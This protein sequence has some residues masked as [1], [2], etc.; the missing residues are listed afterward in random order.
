MWYNG[1]VERGREPACPRYQA[2]LMGNSSR[3]NTYLGVIS[4]FT[5]KYYFGTTIRTRRCS[6]WGSADKTVCNL[7]RQSHRL[8][9]PVIIANLYTG[10]VWQTANLTTGELLDF[11]ED[12]G[13]DT[14]FGYELWS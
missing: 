13:F 9:K 2:T 12:F 1:I 10:E 3:Q 5:I 8:G 4:M 11:P 7:L 6:S 14:T